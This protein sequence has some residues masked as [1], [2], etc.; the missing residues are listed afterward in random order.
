MAIVHD[1]IVEYNPIMTLCKISSTFLYSSGHL[2]TI[3]YV[4]IYIYIYSVIK[5]LRHSIT[6]LLL[7]YLHHLATR[8]IAVF[9]SARPRLESRK[10]AK[11][12]PS[13]G[14]HGCRTASKAKHG[15][16]EAGDRCWIARKIAQ[17][18]T[19]KAPD[20]IIVDSIHGYN[21]VWL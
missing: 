19:N 5:W 17:K 3:N 11:I 18:S 16:K 2:L 9:W 7:L 1:S 21:Y 6:G 12:R 20:I 10:V 15:A 14:S 4:Y 13:S 8:A